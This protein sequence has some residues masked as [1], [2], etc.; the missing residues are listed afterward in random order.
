SQRR[1]T[2]VAAVSDAAISA[3]AITGRYSVRV[4]D[5]RRRARPTRWA[6]TS[7]DRSPRSRRSRT[8]AR[9]ER[10]LL[11][12]DPDLRFERDSEMAL[13]ALA[14]EVEQAE[15]VGGRRAAAIDDVVGLLR[16]DL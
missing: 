3:Q 4:R 7:D 14:R 1:P 9:G 12:D 11:T 2:A 15:D 8:P 16:R 5:R 13:H 6:P 10:S